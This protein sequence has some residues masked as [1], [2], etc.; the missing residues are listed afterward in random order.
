[1]TFIDYLRSWGGNWM[2]EAIRNSSGDISW[3]ITALERGTGIRVM[4]GS[5][6]PN[7]REDACSAS[8]IFF[9]CNT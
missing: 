6:M 7:M 8:W 5:Y 1:M 3:A 2:W 9:C 4:D